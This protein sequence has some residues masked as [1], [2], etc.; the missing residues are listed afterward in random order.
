MTFGKDKILFWEKRGKRPFSHWIKKQFW[1]CANL[2]PLLGILFLSACAT[3]KYDIIS[4]KEIPPVTDFIEADF[5]P[6]VDPQKIEFLDKK[7]AL[8][9]LKEFEFPKVET[10]E[11]ILG[12]GNALLLIPTAH[13]A[14]T[15]EITIT[16]IQANET[17]IYIPSKYDL[18]GKEEVKYYWKPSEE[19]P[20]KLVPY[21]RLGLI[22]GRS[23]NRTKTFLSDMGFIT[24]IGIIKRKANA[25]GDLRSPLVIYIGELDESG[26]GF[27]KYWVAVQFNGIE[28][29][30]LT[31]YYQGK[32]GFL[33]T[34][35]DNSMRRSLDMTPEEYGEFMKL[36]KK[37]YE[38]IS[39]LR[40]G[41]YLLNG[42]PKI[43]FD[44]NS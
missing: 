4:S 36:L 44:G 11:N 34:L 26:T 9:Y 24:P 1:L 18:S 23:K 35:S 42:S 6:L 14:H 31:R 25:M 19:K 27:S 32:H 37:R 43:F 10:D 8:D 28:L 17:G 2:L 29:Q 40:N 41:P 30:K 16:R 20:P 13:S 15:P 12:R 5:S 38:I 33:L 39:D 21:N 7:T 22:I 3:T